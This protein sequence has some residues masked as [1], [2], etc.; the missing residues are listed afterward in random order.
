[1]SYKCAIRKDIRVSEHIKLQNRKIEHNF[2]KFPDNFVVVVV[3]V[4]VDDI[5]T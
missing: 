2:F 5:T 4:V 3:G 1:M